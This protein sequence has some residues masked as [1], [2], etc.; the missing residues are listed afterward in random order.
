M[1][2]THFPESQKTHA[3]LDRLAA[4]QRHFFESR[5][6]AAAHTNHRLGI[7]VAQIRNPSALHRWMT[8]HAVELST[9]ASFETIRDA[10]TCG[11][12]QKPAK[13]TTQP[14]RDVLERLWI[15]DPVLAWTPTRN[16]VRRLSHPPKHQLADPALAARLLGVD[17]DALLS[18]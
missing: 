3:E 16:R 18:G 13:T 1:I 2:G 6:T 5:I 12:G 7:T 9:T 11:E 17:A 8:A 10:E 15:V 4:W 14:Y